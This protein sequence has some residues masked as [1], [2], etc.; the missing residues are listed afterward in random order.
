MVEELA[1][2]K[3]RVGATESLEPGM[4]VVGPKKRIFVVIPQKDNFG[5]QLWIRAREINTQG[6]DPVLTTFVQI[7]PGTLLQVIGKW[8]L[9]VE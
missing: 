3:L 9:D 2:R 1:G 7:L 4:V 8:D 5:H 6:E